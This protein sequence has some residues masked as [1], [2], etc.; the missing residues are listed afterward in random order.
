MYIG[1]QHINR[2]LTVADQYDSDILI[3]E[4]QHLYQ[5]KFFIFNKG[6]F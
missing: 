2:I 6:L 4:S 3:P 1:Y 5:N